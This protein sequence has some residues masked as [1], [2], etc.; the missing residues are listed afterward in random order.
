[1]SLKKKAHQ[2]AS[3]ASSPLLTTYLVNCFSEPTCFS[4]AVNMELGF[5][6]L[7]P[8]NAINSLKRQNDP[9]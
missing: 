8:L 5:T 7:S 9:V 2:A 1:M 3:P 6:L 4:K